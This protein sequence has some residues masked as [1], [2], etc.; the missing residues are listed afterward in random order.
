MN[1]KTRYFILIFFTAAIGL[2]YVWNDTAE[3]R[4]MGGGRSFG[5]RPSY[6]RSAPAPSKSTTSTQTGPTTRQTGAPSAGRFGG[7]GGMFGGMLMGGL[8][9]SMLFGGGHGMGGGPGLLD[10]VIIGGGLFL[11]FRF[12]KNRQMGANAPAGRGGMLFEGGPSQGWGS[13]G[14]TPGENAETVAVRPVLPAGFDGGE[15]LKGAEAIYVRLQDSWDKRDLDD[16]RQF[17]ADAVFSGI[18]QQA[19]EDPTPGKTELLLIKPEIVEVREMNNETIASV[20]FDVMIREDDD[21]TSKQVRE[22]WHFS[23]ERN[24]PGSF[25]ILEGIQQVE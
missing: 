9:G 2:L 8:I 6:Q 11:L 23:K 5:S 1:K 3:A 15:F 22:L 24:N 10:I 13:T 7:I 25:W 12:L 21:R 16:I 19:E 20:L 14:Y 4:R 18:Q 17:T